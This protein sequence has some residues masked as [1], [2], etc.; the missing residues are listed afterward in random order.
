MKNYQWLM[1]ALFIFMLPSCKDAYSEHQDVTGI[2][3]WKAGEKHTYKV[4]METIEPNYDMAINLRHTPKV[5]VDNF[6]IMMKQTAPD[7]TTETKEYTLP[8]RKPNSNEMLGGCSGDFCDTETV[9]MEN[10]KFPAKGTYTYE[11][12]S[13]NKEDIGGMLEI[14]LVIKEIKKK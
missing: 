12:T 4:V 1:M 2:V 11:I 8:M 6:N 5:E 10:F 7:G 3:T 13:K 9:I 14:G